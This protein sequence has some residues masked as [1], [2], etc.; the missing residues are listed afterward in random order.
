M[1]WLA[2]AASTSAQPP[3]PGQPPAPA[4]A[5][6]PSATPEFVGPPPNDPRPPTG[7]DEELDAMTPGVALKREFDRIAAATNLRLGVANTLLFQQASGGPGERT[8]GGGD[9]D[10][11]AKWTAIGAGTT[12]TGILAFAGEYRYQI[13]DQAPSAL[14]GQIGTLLPTTNGFGE[15]P[16]VVKELYWDQRLFDDHF[17]FAVG[18]IDPENLFG[19]HRLQSANFF[20][21]NKAFSSNPTVA[22]PGPGLAAAAQIKPVDWLYVSGGIT[23]AN[24]KATVGNFE[25]FFDDGEFLAFGEFGLTPTIEG[26][27]TGRYRLA[28]WHVDARDDADVPSD[29][30]ITVSLDQDIGERITVFARYGYADGEVTSVTNSVQGGVGIKKVLAKEDMLGV[31]AAW[32]RS[33]A[34]DKRDEKVVEVFHRFQ[35]TETSQFTIGAEVIFDPS[36]APDDDVLGVFSARL[37]IAF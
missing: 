29:Q 33:A 3:E 12:D 6:A 22:Y 28:L 15:R 4:E 31:A 13:G 7:I 18:R 25:G 20:F 37:R 26:L 30:G 8:A 16:V 27:G 14:G 9:L 11:L 34:E 10:L 35:V 5:S 23:D 32:S 17:R 19:G 24:G 1:A 21:F 2:A 36:N